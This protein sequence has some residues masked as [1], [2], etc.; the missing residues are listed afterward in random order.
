MR[1]AIP[2]Y[3][4]ARLAAEYVKVVL[5][6]EGADELFAGYRYHKGYLD[7][8]ALG[9]ELRRSVRSLHNINLQRLDR[10]T[11]AHGVEGRVPFLD[12][13]LVSLAQRIKPG[14]KLRARGRAR[15]VEKWVLRAACEDLLPSEI[16]WREKQQFDEGSGTTD[17]LPLALED[18][19]AMMHTG[20]YV[21]AQ[22]EASLRSPE[23]CVYHALL[24]SAYPE[25]EPVLRSVARW[26]HRLEE[27]EL[28]L[29]LRGHRR[30]EG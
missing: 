27:P 22:P 19:V 1:S 23:E 6:G 5:T 2:C 13:E 28:Q 24:S 4:A 17:L 8:E 21:R 7:A 12:L 3:F 25:P 9:R 14:L 16:L 29:T 18:W 10:M 11:M 30:G 26:S 15:V 20:D